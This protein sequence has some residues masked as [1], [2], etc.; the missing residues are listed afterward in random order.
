MDQNVSQVQHVDVLVLPET[1]L[2]LVASVIEPMRAANRIAGRP[3]YDW[4]IYSPDGAPI[5]TKSGIPIPVSGIFR[6]QRETSPLFILSSYNWQRSATSQ[7]K[8]LLSQTARHR[9]LMA[10]IESGSWLLAETSLLDNFK[11]TTHWEDFEDFTAAYPQVTMVRERFVIDGKR[12]TTGGSLPTLDL[13]LELIRRAHG[14]SLALEVSRL[15][16]YEQERTR[17]D[18][19]QMPTIGNMRIL[20]PRVGAA[21]KLMEETVEA[22]LT[23]ARLARRI[24]VST[25]HLQDLFRDTMGVAPH[26][27]YLALRLNAARRKVIETRMEFADIAAISGFNSSSSFSRSYRAHYRE[28]PSETRRRLKLK[29]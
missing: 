17:G 11:A 19:L 9:E 16:I 28:S 27:H 7:L 22:P 2:I 20:D 3:L 14:Y 4:T 18:L 25:R 24:G 12:I 15:F 13:M 8:M 6:P 5:E 1:N 21:V 29:S 23:L 10:G 26:E